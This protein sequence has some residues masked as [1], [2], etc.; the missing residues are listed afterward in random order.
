MDKKKFLDQLLVLEED[1]GWRGI[2][3]WPKEIQQRCAQML[4]AGL[5]SGSE[6]ASAMNV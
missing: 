3:C 1:L 5:I 6:L 4:S 2:K